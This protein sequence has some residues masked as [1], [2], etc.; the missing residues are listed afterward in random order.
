MQQTRKIMANHVRAVALWLSSPLHCAHHT[1]ISRHVERK[2][3]LST[4]TTST[5]KYRNESMRLHL[6]SGKCNITYS[7]NLCTNCNNS[8]RLNLF[9]HI[10][11]CTHSNFHS[12][13]CRRKENVWHSSI[14][15]KNYIPSDYK[16]V[17]VSGGF[18]MDA[19]YFLLFIWSVFL[20]LSCCITTYLYEHEHEHE[21]DAWKLFNW[22]V[23]T[24]NVHT[25]REDNFTLIQIQCMGKRKGACKIVAN[26][27]HFSMLMKWTAFLRLDTSFSFRILSLPFCIF[28]DA[29]GST[30]THT[31]THWK[32]VVTTT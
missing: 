18:S 13:K 16:C 1:Q 5:K 32:V 30:N 20:S 25:E 21:H 31:H 29:R 14:L 15:G 27:R 23:S 11:H 17:L 9:T 4:T 26:I 24:W 8:R 12:I 3:N 10:A 22:K 6:M 7:D 19:L 28:R 2:T